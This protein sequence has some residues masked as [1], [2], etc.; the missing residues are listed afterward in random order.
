MYQDVIAAIATP[1][2]EGGIAV[3]RLSG[4]L[5]LA[6]AKKC[7]RRRRGRFSPKP[8]RVYY[9]E[10]CALGGER[11][12]ECLLTYF[13][14]PHS[15]TGEDVVEFGV[16]GGSFVAGRVLERLL[17]CGA[18]LAAPGE[19]TKRAFLNGRIDLAQA[20]AV[21][22]VIRA[23][24][25]LA[26]RNA[27]L[28]LQGSLRREILEIRQR[29]LGALALVEAHLDFPDLDA[30]LLTHSEVEAELALAA[31]NLD[32]LVA[33]ARGGRVVR[34]G[35][36]VALIGRPNVGKSSLFNYLAGQERAIVTSI[37]GTTRD[38]LEVTI[39]HEGL[40]LKL[41]DTAGLRAEGDFLERLGMERTEQTMEQADFVLLLIDASEELHAEDLSLLERTANFKRHIVLTKSDLPPR[42][43][44]PGENAWLG[45]SAHTG[46]GVHELRELIAAAARVTLGTQAQF[47]TNIRH[48]SAL[49]KARL[50]TE[51]AMCAAKAG[52]ELEMVVIDV[53]RAL[54][55]L[56]EITGDDV[57]HGLT[58]EIF[59]QFCIGK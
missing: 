40:L 1:P 24:S 21:I 51:T 58:D 16:H 3:V 20:E 31:E 55:L 28:H 45:V 47:V 27:N 50:A 56:G 35:F 39:N 34:E 10:V 49:S 11:I 5:A 37:A 7:F 33:T 13:R 17:E 9:G 4:E 46:V 44:L 6:V 38:V 36:R 42:V 2:G 30:P 41:F 54:A 15:Y 26:L 48:T 52:W 43:V 53:R 57:T 29:L 14:A 25:D 59:A 19:F 23:S 32:S 8:W 18:A 22:D 12:D